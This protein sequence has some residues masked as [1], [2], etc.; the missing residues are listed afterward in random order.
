MPVGEPT[1]PDAAWTLPAV[2][3]TVGQMRRHA[4]G[5]AEAAGASEELARAVALA[6]S[7][8]V[9]NA[10]VHATSAA[11][12]GSCACGAGPTAGA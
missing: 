2:P 6:V 1:G 3:A 5:F 7:E 10:V 4:A 12:P 8:T 9:T 11:S